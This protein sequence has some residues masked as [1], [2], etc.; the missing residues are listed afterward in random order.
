MKG[1][2]QHRRPDSESRKAFALT[3][4]HAVSP[5]KGNDAAQPSRHLW[6]PPDAFRIL[7]ALSNNAVW[8]LIAPI[9]ALALTVLYIQISNP[10]YEIGAQVM[11]RFGQELAAPP[12]VSAQSR[13]Q[14]VP[15]S[16][17]L[18]DTTAEVQIM[19]DPELVRLVVE[20]L[21]V[22]FFYAE[23]EPVTLLQKIKRALSHIVRDIKE[24]IRSFMVRIGVL[25]ELSRK[26]RVI[27]YLQSALSIEH[28][29]RSDVIELKLKYPDPELGEEILRRFLKHYFEKREKIYRDDMISA[30]FAG[31]IEPIEQALKAAEDEYRATRESLRAWSVEDQRS[32][33]VRRHEALSQ[34]LGDTLSAI[35]SAKARLRE[36]EEALA[37]TPEFVPSLSSRHANP[38]RDQ[39]ELK[40]IDLELQLD[41][42]KRRFGE[43]SQQV[44]GLMRKI[45][46]LKGRLATEPEIVQN[47]VVTKSNPLR[48][49]LKKEKLDTE[50][51]ISGSEVHA[52]NL[53][54]ELAGLEQKLGEL[55]GAGLALMRKL[56][57]VERLRRKYERYQDGL[58]EARI[59]SAISEA[60]ISNVVVI[61]DPDGGVAPVKPRVFRLFVVAILFSLI[62]ASGLILLIDSLR[63]KIR[64]N[65]DIVDQ[66]GE[67]TIVRAVAEKGR[68]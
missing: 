45:E 33:R 18:E 3:A 62:A 12:T 59:A 38:M 16:K 30:F 14:V 21:G 63:P 55:D 50:L 29:S 47:E 66:V 23:P 32:L 53:R 24:G 37:R 27:L 65:R 2:F 28:V 51:M 40:L 36:I 54:A 4:E 49:A 34:E 52:E 68:R 39:L 9:L 13:Q 20:D 56:R 22:D 11:V 64:S 6:T 43:K 1:I 25:P 26:D 7:S 10:S 61:A 44:L 15:I 42:D 31:E 57:D 48:E 5:G 19:K 46:E 58:D 8:L 35:A 41:S 17:R 60:N 67:R